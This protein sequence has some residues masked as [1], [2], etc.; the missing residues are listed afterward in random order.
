MNKH[1]YNLETF[2]KE[3]AISYYLLGAWITDGCIHKSK[4]RPNRKSTTL[5]SKDK[6]WLELINQYICP[7]KPLLKHGLNCF[8]LMYCSTEMADWFIQKGCHERKSL[9]IKFPKVPQKYMA[10]FIRGCWDGDGSLSFT[11]SGNKGKTW[12]S[13]ANLT[14]GSLSF[15]KKLTKI[16][17]K[18]GI[19]CSI[20]VHGSP[21]RKIE[22]RLITSN[23]CWRVV[24]SGGGS[25]YNLV[26]LLYPKDSLLSMPRKYELAQKIIQFREE[27]FQ[28]A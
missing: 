5:T 15:C 1:I 20:Y 11:K 10:D 2:Y 27:K 16:L 19:K 18:Q 13:Q 26:K 4:D 28:P 25:V 22:G 7:A 9:T 3:N 21:Q 23:P 14:S 8:R 6:D 12:Q 24:L 17:N